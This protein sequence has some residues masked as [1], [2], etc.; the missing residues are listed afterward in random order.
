MQ[1]DSDFKWNYAVNV[2]IARNNFILQVE[3]NQ[4]AILLFPLNSGC[5]SHED[6]IKRIEELI[7]TENK[8]T[9]GTRV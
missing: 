8:Y 9:Q 2:A 4:I 7:E 3:K 5:V 1:C 6:V